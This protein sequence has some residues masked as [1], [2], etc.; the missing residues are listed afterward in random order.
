MTACLLQPLAAEGRLPMAL[1]VYEYVNRRCSASA[2]SRQ[3]H[4]WPAAARWLRE[5]AGLSWVPEQDLVTAAGIND[6]NGVNLCALN[7]GSEVSEWVSE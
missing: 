7:N 6:I 4:D 5:E 3:Q 2:Q 1:G